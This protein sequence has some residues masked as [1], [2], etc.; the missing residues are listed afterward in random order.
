LP[1]LG[2]PEVGIMSRDH[3]KLRVFTMADD[4]AV[5]VYHLTESLPREE[6]FGLS[7]QLR[8][9]AVSVAANIVEGCAR[10]TTRDYGRFLNI[11]FGSAA[12]SRY[13][14]QLSFR[15][16]ML[17]KREFDVA[18]VACDQLLR[19]L[20]KLIQAVSQMPQSREP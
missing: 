18:D 4:L 7:A 6:R 15:L 14:L 16:R 12:E 1:A 20:Q 19:A 3:R 17:P 10:A 5:R 8:R 13:L 2:L 11:A 9:A